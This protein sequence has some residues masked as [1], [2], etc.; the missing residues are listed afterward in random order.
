MFLL[1]VPPEITLL[2]AN[3]LDSLKDLSSFS[4]ASR[5]LHNL[6]INEMYRR[7]VRLDGG[8]ALL[9]YAS[10]GDE[11][12]IR[13][14]L[15]AGA[16][17]NLRS[18]NR[19]QSTALLKAVAAKH[20]H[21][22]QILLENGALPDAVDAR[23]RRP[24][25][26]ATNGRSNV[27]I[28]KLLLDHGARVNSAALDKHAPLLE[29][30]RSNQECKVELL[31][32]HGADSHVVEGRTG[33][34]LLHIA[35]W[36]N[37]TPGIMKRL[38]DTGIQV[39]SQDYRGRTPLQVAAE[40]SC[41]RAVRVLL[42][43]GAN[44]NFTDMREGWTAIFYAATRPS[45]PRNDNKTIIQTLVMHGS[46]LEFRNPDQATPLLH[47]ISQ[48][49]FKQAQALIECGASIMAR[50][51][52]DETVLHLAASSCSFWCCPPSMIGWLVTS[53]ADVNWAGGQH[54]ETPIFYAISRNYKIK[55]EEYVRAL[56]SLGADVHFRNDDGLT[57]L[58]LAVRTGSMELTKMLLEHGAFPN[59]RDKQGKGPLHHAAE[60]R[61]VHNIV[62][63]LLQ[64]GAD[65]NSQD[66]FG[67]T[68]LHRIIAK[69]TAWETVGDMLKAGAERCVISNDGKFPH[70]MV[71]D[72]PWAETK[73]LWIRFYMPMAPS[74]P[75]N[76]T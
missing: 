69:E 58:S 16:N 73:R 26:L 57:P 9:W 21:A 51:A 44:P 74:T 62:K 19:A 55:A 64:N 32:K 39:E 46:E 30:V 5:K 37:A 18:P 61:N 6:L 1:S 71:P 4:R 66:N 33:M 27:D 43:L 65:V 38:I 63:L 53:G 56:L 28:T 41:T 52:H 15:R 7:S 47:A 49:A 23:S 17:V 31:L 48:G 76:S 10:R 11:L 13:N 70:D 20:T 68:P 67:Y 8:S 35:A 3:N 50:N 25:A 60:S 54:R 2:I 24:L 29:A 12:G 34:N 14:M 22:V 36:K 42:H 40:H 59:T 45:N 72:G 75:S